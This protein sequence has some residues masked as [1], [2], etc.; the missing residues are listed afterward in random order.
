MESTLTAILRQVSTAATALPGLR[1]FAL[2]QVV[3]GHLHKAERWVVRDAP[4]SSLWMQWPRR[5]PAPYTRLAAGLNFI[6]ATP[7]F[8]C[9]DARRLLPVRRILR[10]CS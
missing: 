8:C 4:Q 10:E 2:A 7:E 1:E 9:E 5:G 3:L 6:D